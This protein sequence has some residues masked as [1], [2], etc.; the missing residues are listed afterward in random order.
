MYILVGPELIPVQYLQD[1]TCKED[2]DFDAP[3]DEILESFR[4]YLFH[5]DLI[6]R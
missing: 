4:E 2:I 5:I 3:A 6:H 1:L